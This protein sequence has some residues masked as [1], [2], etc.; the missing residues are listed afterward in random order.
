MA[1]SIRL[2][3]YKQRAEAIHQ[4]VTAYDVLR[5]IGVLLSQTTDDKE[6]QFSCPFHGLDNKP[7]ARVYPPTEDSHSH[8]WCYV[9]QQS[10]WDA[11][12]LWRRQNDCSF[13]EALS[14]LERSFGLTAPP[15][16]AGSKEAPAPPQE[17][18]DLE[19]FKKTFLACANHLIRKRPLYKKLDDMVGF[20]SAGSVLDKTKYRVDKKVWSPEK[21]LRVLRTLFDRMR[22]KERQ[23]PDG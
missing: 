3:W 17:S 11:I 8:V 13:G 22:E 5:A 23:C 1:D 7:S 18:K 15:M 2:E 9:C 4:R 16:P 6:E 21:G 12:G 20:L 14:G 10:G 19:L